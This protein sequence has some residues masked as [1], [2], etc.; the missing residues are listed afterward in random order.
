[1]Q[2]YLRAPGWVLL[3][4]SLRLMFWSGE[5]RSPEVELGGE[6]VGVALTVGEVETCNSAHIGQLKSRNS[7]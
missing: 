5:E 3:L 7:A 6:G 2:P 4:M 1:M